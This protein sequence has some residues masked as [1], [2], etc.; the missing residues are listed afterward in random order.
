MKQ[1]EV[2]EKVGITP[3]YLRLIEKG[4]INLKLKLMIKLSEVLEVDMITLFF[5]EEE[6]QKTF[7]KKYEK[8]E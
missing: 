7:N 8:K 1:K 2:A 4:E 3:Q 5:D 6:I